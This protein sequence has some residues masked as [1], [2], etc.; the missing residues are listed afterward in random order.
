MTPSLLTKADTNMKRGFYEDL[1]NFV[2]I[3]NELKPS[4][5]SELFN[6]TIL[7]TVHCICKWAEQLK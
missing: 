3:C 5:Q 4:D 6:L 7:L 1:Y 2:R